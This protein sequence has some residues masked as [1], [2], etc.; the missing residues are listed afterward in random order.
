MQ[1]AD[2]TQR[3]VSVEPFMEKSKQFWKSPASGQNY[4]V[5]CFV[6]IPELNAELEVKPIPIEQEI[7]SEHISKYEA[8]SEISGTYKSQKCS[9]FCYI[10]YVG[11]FK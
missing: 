3:V 6:K 1:N 5:H 11:I 7:A 4:P 10:E 2:G 8:A 9:G